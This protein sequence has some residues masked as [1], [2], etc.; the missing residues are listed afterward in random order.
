[1]DGKEELLLE[2]WKLAS[3]LH[4]HE[5]SLTWQKFN[6]YITLNGILLSVLCVV[7]SDFAVNPNNPNLRLVSAVIC[8]FGAL[9]SLVWFAMHKRGQLYQHYRI[10]QAKEIE[11]DLKID[12]EQVLDL[13]AKGLNEQRLISIPRV[14]RCSI[15]NLVSCLALA[16]MIVYSGLFIVFLAL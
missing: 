4:R 1:M 2:E 7:W 6:Y 10:A 14:F 12:G 11:K 16:L 8:A 5:D 15:Q 3:E 9:V 13:Y